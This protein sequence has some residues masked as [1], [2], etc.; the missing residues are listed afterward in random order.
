MTS[1]PDSLDWRRAPADAAQRKTDAVTA[2]ALFGASILS[3]VLGRAVGLWEDPASPALSAG[4]LALMTLP[5]AFRRVAPRSQP[6]L[7]TR[8]STGL[9]S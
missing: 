8:R 6:A 3:L 4:L 9:A 7:R 5:L 1:D 2:V